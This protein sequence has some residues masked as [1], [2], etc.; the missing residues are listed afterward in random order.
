MDHHVVDNDQRAND[1]IRNDVEIDDDV[2]E[3]CRTAATVWLETLQDL[4]N[5]ACGRT[6][7]DKDNDAVLQCQ[8]QPD[9]ISEKQGR[10]SQLY[11]FRYTRVDGGSMSGPPRQ[12]AK[13]L[14]QDLRMRL[15]TDY[16]PGILR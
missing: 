16:G 8:V 9:A 6:A 12:L 5:Q 15:Q 7:S 2:Q 11:K 14:H 1:A 4:V 10:W 13:D 3:A